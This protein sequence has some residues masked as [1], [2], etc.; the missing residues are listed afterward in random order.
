MHTLTATIALRHGY[1][2]KR[3]NVHNASQELTK[4]SQ[5]MHQ[6]ANQR[7]WSL[8]ETWA[9]V[10]FSTTLTMNQIQSARIV[11]L[12]S[13]GKWVRIGHLAVNALSQ[14][15]T[16]I[17]WTKTKESSTTIQKSG[18]VRDAKPRKTMSQYV[19]RSG[20]SQE[21]ITLLKLLQ[22]T[23]LYN[24]MLTRSLQEGKRFEDQTQK[25]RILKENNF[26]YSTLQ[27]RCCH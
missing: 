4:S 10:L 26:Q 13:L 12:S 19:S 22:L 24:P 16:K 6:E 3:I 8:T 14:S 9:S 1:R 21:W 17:A 27:H 20:W 11:K 2:H 5:W 15:S 7:G 25:R 18:F 23:G